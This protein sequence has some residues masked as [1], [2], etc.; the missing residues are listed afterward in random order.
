MPRLR[1]LKLSTGSKLV[2]TPT[3]RIPMPRLR[4]LKPKPGDLH[5]AWKLPPYTHA[6]FEGIETLTLGLIISNAPRPVYPCP[7]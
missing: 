6:P 5:N 1:G 3:P 7:V 2:L 4:G